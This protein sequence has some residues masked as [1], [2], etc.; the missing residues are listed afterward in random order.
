MERRRPSILL[1]LVFGLL[2]SEKP[3][4]TD[5]TKKYFGPLGFIVLSQLKFKYFNLA[6]FSKYV[7]PNF[8][9]ACPSPVV[10]K[11][12]DFL[13]ADG[14]SFRAWGICCSQLWSKPGKS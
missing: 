11:G 12:S 2:D 10:E 4:P 8:L 6:S 7:F 1:W 5:R 3:D 13:F 9:S 14:G